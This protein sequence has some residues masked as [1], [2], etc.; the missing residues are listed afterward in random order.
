MD[1]CDVVNGNPQVVPV[2]ATTATA[3]VAAFTQPRNATFCD[4]VT[5][6]GAQTQ[7]KVAAVYTLPYDIQASA[8]FQ[9]FPGRPT[10]VGQHRRQQRADLPVSRPQ[11]LGRC[12]PR[13][14]SSMSCRST[15]S[16]RKRR[17]RP[18]SA[19][20]RRSG[21]AG[22]ARCRAIF[23]IYNAFNARPVLGV[24][25]RYSRRDRRRLAAPDQH[26]R[27][28]AAQVRRAV[29]LL[30]RDTSRPVMVCGNSADCHR[31]SLDVRS[32]LLSGPNN[33][34]PPMASPTRD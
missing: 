2:V 34:L 31:S 21:W 14:S 19:S 5:P 11:P 32:G 27:R 20:S 33:R 23:D 13:R 25:T 17:A 10:Q 29:R 3:G 15:S 1:Y 28:T 16:S 22:R 7:V 18:T 6:W 8:S 26:A 12:R 30:S 4:T 9:H 24:D